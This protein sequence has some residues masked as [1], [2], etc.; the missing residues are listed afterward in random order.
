MKIITPQ[1]DGWQYFFGY[2]DLQP[3]DSKM[4]YHLCH[5]VKFM[6]RLPVESDVCEIGMIDLETNE[7]IKLS[8]TTAF[9]FQQG[10]L[11]RWFRDDDH[12][13][14]NIYDGEAYRT[15]V[16]NIKTGETK[17]YPMAFADMSLDGKRAVCINFSRIYDFRPGYGYPQIKDKNFDV[18]APADDGVFLMD[19]D[20]GECKLILTYEELK[21]KLPQKPYSDGKLLVNHITFKPKGDR[22]LFLLRNF[23]APNEKKWK[24]MLAS[25]DLEGNVCALT[26]YCVNSHY[27]WKNDKE[28]LIVTNLKTEAKEY[29]LYLIEDETA[30]ATKLPEPNPTDDIHCIYSPDR[31]Y[32]AG[33]DYPNINNIRTIWLIDTETD[34]IYRGVSSYSVPTD[35][36]DIRCDLHVRW[37]PDGKYLTYDSTHT[38]SRCV[39]MV[40][41][42]EM[43]KTNW[44]D[45]WNTPPLK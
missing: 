14:Y 30:K 2:Y 18:N 44:S 33:D 19:M 8:E 9:N 16:K 24:T 27:H 20:S 35:N 40:T 25:S 4:K 5:R 23:P 43:L 22:F 38:N 15:E 13:V 7:F 29:A 17:R 28:I 39:C 34:R 42:E 3:F 12:I 11:L 36:T 6:D 45:N 21:N 10:S 31:R 26:E 41:L 37:S 32:I 1:N